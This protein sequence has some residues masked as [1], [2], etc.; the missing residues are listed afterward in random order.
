M[1]PKPIVMAESTQTAHQDDSYDE[2]TL[3]Q[4]SPLRLS[5]F[6]GADHQGLARVTIDES[7]L[8]D[9]LN[10]NAIND[11]NWAI[12]ALGSL[13][14][15]PNLV[16]TIR[17]T[18]KDL[19][20]VSDPHDSHERGGH[21][22]VATFKRKTRDTLQFDTDTEIDAGLITVFDAINAIHDFIVSNAYGIEPNYSMLL[23]DIKYLNTWG[24]LTEHPVFNI[25]ADVVKWGQYQLAKRQFRLPNENGG[26][27][28]YPDCTYL[29]TP[30]DGTT[31]KRAAEAVATHRDTFV[32]DT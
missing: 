18:W 7:T 30:D 11:M 27:C 24:D 13:V 23:T 14:H 32:F 4:T 5:A 20:L 10:E 22:R 29:G 6:N 26:H 15:Y 17:T 12:Q 19:V 28:A 8:P 1:H 31:H 16:L 3:S 2:H 25:D 21:I 9:D